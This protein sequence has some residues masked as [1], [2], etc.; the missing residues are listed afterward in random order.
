MTAVPTPL[1]ITPLIM[2]PL[3]SLMMQ[4]LQCGTGAAL[5]RSYGRREPST[6]VGIWRFIIFNQLLI[7]DYF[8]KVDMPT[9]CAK[10][11]VEVSPG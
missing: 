6:G 7:P 4:L 11:A 5:Q 2:P 1:E 3:G 9:D 10:L 8:S